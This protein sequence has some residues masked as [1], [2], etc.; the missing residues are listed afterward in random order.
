MG[1]EA[2]DATIARLTNLEGL[3]AQID[4]QTDSKQILDLQARI[5]TEQGAIQNEQTKLQ[6]MS[7]LQQ[8]E[9]GLIEAQKDAVTHD[10]FSTSNSEI[11]S[12]GE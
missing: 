7:M 4:S 1:E 8:S 2:Y 9:Q 12:L 10:V 3:A 6:L 11:P 5:Q